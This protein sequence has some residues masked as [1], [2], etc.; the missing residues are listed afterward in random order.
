MA[1]LELRA[2]EGGVRST[3]YASHDG[4]LY[5]RYHDTGTWSEPLGFSLDERGVARCGGNRRVDALV[6]QAWAEAEEDASFR[7]S[8][9]SSAPSTTRR[10]A[11]PPPHL[12][13]ALQ[14]LVRGVR[15]VDALARACGVARATAWSYACRAVERWPDAH[16]HARALVHAPLLDAVRALPDR[17]GPLRGL[18]DQLLPGDV[19]WR[20]VDDRYAHLRLARLCVEAE[21]EVRHDH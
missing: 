12:R 9:S 6:A 13:R 21:D 2:V 14:H 1:P 17:R 16:V 5:R 4:A 20:C 7:G 3:L 10:R 15:D 8:S 19:A 18:M 11:P